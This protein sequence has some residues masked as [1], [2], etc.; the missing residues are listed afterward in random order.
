MLALKAFDATV[1]EGFSSSIAFLLLAV[2][3]PLMP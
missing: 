1:S 2:S 3:R